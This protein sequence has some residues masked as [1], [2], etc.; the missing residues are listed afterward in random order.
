MK[1]WYF[2]C[3]LSARIFIDHPNLQSNN[4]T[5]MKNYIR[6]N[7]ILELILIVINVCNYKENIYY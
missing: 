7:I 5:K 2:I 3:N 4:F 1:E 6:F